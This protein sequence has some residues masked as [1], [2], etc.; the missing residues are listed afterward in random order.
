MKKEEIK[1]QL[2][3]WDLEEGDFYHE[4]IFQLYRESRGD[5]THP[6]HQSTYADIELVITTHNDFV[7]ETIER[8]RLNTEGN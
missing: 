6:F 2:D 7:R 3:L 4:S 5:R 1:K 8:Q